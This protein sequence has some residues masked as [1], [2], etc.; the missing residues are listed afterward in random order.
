M[1]PVTAPAAPQ[2]VSFI[3]AHGSASRKQAVGGMF[4]P[5]RSGVTR[6][7][8]RELVHHTL[9]ARCGQARGRDSAARD[10]AIEKGQQKRS[11]QRSDDAE[12]QY[13]G[14]VLPENKPEHYQVRRQ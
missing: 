14:G 6:I 11:Q 12:N 13:G 5:A 7:A 9:A 4:L 2:K 3:S 1:E 8:P 10:A